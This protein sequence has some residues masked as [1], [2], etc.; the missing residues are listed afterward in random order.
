LP[1]TRQQRGLAAILAADV[2]GYTRA[3]GADEA[4]THARL[5]ALLR[6]TIRPEVLARGGRVFK[7]M[8]DGCLAE[9]PSAVDAAQCAAAIQAA[10]A[11]AG[12]SLQLRIGLHLGDVIVE[13]DDLFGDGVNIAARLQGEAAPGS[14]VASAAF[15]QHVEGRAGLTFAEAG[16]RSLKNVAEPVEIFTLQATGAP[17]APQTRR[18]RSHP[19]R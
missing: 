9:F 10:Q 5:Q 8:G 17:P 18:Q 3:M 2:A 16:T 13:G 6:E 12:S 15:R 19:L 1:E 4:G 11:A 14:V 7:E